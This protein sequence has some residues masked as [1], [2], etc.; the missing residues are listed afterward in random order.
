MRSSG[1]PYRCAK[2]AASRPETFA[3]STPRNRKLFSA[4]FHLDR[5]IQVSKVGRMRKATRAPQATAAHI[6]NTQDGD[7]YPVTNTLG[8]TA[9]NSAVGTWRGLP[10]VL[11]T[12]R[13]EEHT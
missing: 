8:C 9:A 1:M 12:G 10:N 4:S 11:R 5:T 7:E 2:A 13:S 6:P 3:P